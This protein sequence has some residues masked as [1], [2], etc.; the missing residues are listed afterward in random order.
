[1]RPKPGH[2]PKKSTHP[3]CGNIIFVLLSILITYHNEGALLS[4]CIESFLRQVHVPDEILIF[5]DASTLRPDSYVGPGIRIYRSEKNLGPSKARNELLKLARGEYVHFHDSDDWVMPRWS[6]HVMPALRQGDVDIVFTEVS[7]FTQ[8]NLWVREVME[9]RDLKD[10]ISFALG[11]FLLVPSGTYRRQLV[12]GTGG[13][14]EELWQS[15]DFLYHIRLL[16]KHPSISSIPDPLVGIDIRERGRS[17]KSQEVWL[18][19]LQALEILLPEIPPRYHPDMAEMAARVGSAL[20][21]LGRVRS[22]GRAFSIARR[23]GGARFD[24]RNAWF[25]WGARR[26]PL[27]AEY[28]AAFFRWLKRRRKIF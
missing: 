17:K 18:S 4:R 8:G 27:T 23:L 10:P 16:L 22:A 9:L 25:R 7:S 5:D 1:M 6:E 11:H 24:R 26:M 2:L 28:A 12:L 19:T 20:F 21:G 15:E 13:Y 14:P 3:V